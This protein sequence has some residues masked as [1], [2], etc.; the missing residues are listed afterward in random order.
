MTAQAESGRATQSNALPV[1]LATPDVDD[2]TGHTDLATGFLHHFG[3]GGASVPFPLALLATTA[4]RTRRTRSPARGEP[5]SPGGTAPTCPPGPAP[6]VAQ[7][8]GFHYTTAHRHHAAAGGTWNRYT[9]R[10]G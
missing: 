7:A 3:R 6:V 10:D 8:L 2:H 1:E 9:G 4:D 5:R